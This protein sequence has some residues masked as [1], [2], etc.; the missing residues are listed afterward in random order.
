MMFYR[1]G[2]HFPH[3]TA[4]LMVSDGLCLFQG[5]G[6]GPKQEQRVQDQQGPRQQDQNMPAPPGQEREDLQPTNKVCQGFQPPDTSNGS[7]SSDG[8]DDLRGPNA[9]TKPPAAAGIFPFSPN[10]Y[11]LIRFAYSRY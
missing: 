11:F 3:L 2:L 9:A 10:L 6:P 4:F 5:S 1:F 7:L 8:E